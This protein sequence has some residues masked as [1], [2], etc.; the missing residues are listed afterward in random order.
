[1]TTLATATANAAVDTIVDR[2]EL[3]SANP[4]GRLVLKA[5]AVTIATF[6]LNNPAAGAASGGSATFAGLPKVAIAVAS[7]TVNN[8]EVQNRDGTVVFSGTV[9]GDLTISNP[10]ITLGQAINLNSLSFAV[11]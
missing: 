8:L 9:P 6:L 4:E 7:G 3:G 5:T 1:M 10:S 2:I 11:V